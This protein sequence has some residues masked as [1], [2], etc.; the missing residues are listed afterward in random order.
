GPAVRSVVEEPDLPDDRPPRADDAQLRA[1]QWT[2]AVVVI[3]ADRRDRVRELEDGQRPGLADRRLLDRASGPG[4]QPGRLPEEVTG[5]VE[6]VDRV[7]QELEPGR[8]A[9]ELP[10]REVRVDRDVEGEPL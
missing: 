6:V 10:L 4:R 9:Q 8:P 2:C 1:V 5:R 7:V 3:G